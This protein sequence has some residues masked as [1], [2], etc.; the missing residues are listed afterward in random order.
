MVSSI[1]AAEA[2]SRL[3][4]TDR[5]IVEEFRDR[6][7]ELLGPR[8]RD[9]R[10]FGSKARGD[11]H[12]ESDIDVLVLVENLDGKT[13]FAVIDL[14]SEIGYRGRKFLAPV[15]CDFDKYHAP[16]SR[17]TGFYESMRRESIRL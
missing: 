3:H 13:N 14:A 8:L 10:L 7:R 1:T 16:K 15:V 5:A 4:P 17:A 9:L 11:D 12:D 6:V 2:L